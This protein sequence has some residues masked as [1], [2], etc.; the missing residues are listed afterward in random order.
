MEIKSFK[1]RTG[2]EVTCE[3]IG[4]HDGGI[5]VKNPIMLMNTPENGIQMVGWFQASCGETATTNEQKDRTFTFT[6]EMFWRE[7][8]TMDYIQKS[9]AQEFGSGI[10]IP[11]QKIT[12]A[13]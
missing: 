5:T 2:E 4:R 1:M 6:P 13:L 12:A 11:D 10:V 3:I 8:I 7:G 9:Y